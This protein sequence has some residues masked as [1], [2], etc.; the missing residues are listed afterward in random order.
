M[1][2]KIDH[3]FHKKR[4]GEFVIMLLKNKAVKAIAGAVILSCIMGGNVY[5]ASSPTSVVIYSNDS[6]ATSTSIN[7]TGYIDGY[8]VNDVSSTISLYYTLRKKEVIGSS[9]AYS[10]LMSAGTGKMAS[11]QV[12]KWATIFTQTAVMSGPGEYF[13]K[14]NPHGAMTNGCYGAGKLVD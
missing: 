14:L 3:G 12:S 1:D 2:N 4:K 11:G 10:H 13:I 5:A 9:E 6:S 7:C 8:G